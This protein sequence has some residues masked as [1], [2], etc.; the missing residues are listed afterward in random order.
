M[1]VVDQV[2]AEYQGRVEFIAVAGRS[3]LGATEA[4][5]ER[6]FGPNI[7]WGLDE[8]IW[9]LYGARYQ[10]VTVTITADGRVADSWYGAIGAEE[11]RSVVDG[12]LAES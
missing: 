4:M 6:L 2:A 1:P 12:L 7:K 11:I 8:S 10:P 5:A 3:D 9:D